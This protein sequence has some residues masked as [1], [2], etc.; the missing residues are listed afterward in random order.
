MVAG[1]LSTA[2]KI[3]GPLPTAA[4]GRVSLRAKARTSA[5]GISYASAITRLCDDRR[6]VQQTP[7]REHPITSPD[8][9]QCFEEG[10]W[11]LHGQH[12]IICIGHMLTLSSVA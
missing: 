1:D 12:S 6:L 10:D 2:T 11:L 5:Q 9:E 4:P 7:D 8:I 3:H